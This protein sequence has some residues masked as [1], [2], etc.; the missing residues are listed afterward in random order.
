[1]GKRRFRLMRCPFC[2][3]TGTFTAVQVENNGW[4]ITCNYDRGGCGCTSGWYAELEKIPEGFE[5]VEYLEYGHPVEEDPEG[6]SERVFP[7]EN[8]GGNAG[9]A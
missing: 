4:Y 6:Q 7:H 1:M 9:N 8:E 3:R 2:K 5:I